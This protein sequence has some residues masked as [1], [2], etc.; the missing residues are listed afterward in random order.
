MKELEVWSNT[1]MTTLWGGTNIDN[2]ADTCSLCITCP[3]ER[4]LKH[5]LLLDNN[6]AVEQ[7]SLTVGPTYYCIQYAMLNLP[8]RVGY[9]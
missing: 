7:L 6:L 4:L 5:R 9:Y 3:W 1:N 8:A 2:L